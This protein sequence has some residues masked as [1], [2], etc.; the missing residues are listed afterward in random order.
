MLI[1]VCLCV[2]IYTIAI[3]IGGIVGKYGRFDD[4]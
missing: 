4:D 1:V 3:V 2:A